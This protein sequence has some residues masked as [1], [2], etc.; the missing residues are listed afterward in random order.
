MRQRVSYAKLEHNRSTQFHAHS[1]KVT[2]SPVGGFVLEPQRGAARSA[3]CEISA[4]RGPQRGRLAGGLGGGPGWGGLGGPGL[5]GGG[6]GGGGLGGGLGGGGE[7]HAT[8]G[9]G[10]VVV[11]KAQARG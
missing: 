1:R 9:S 5:G 11:P 10:E 4:R 3:C 7:T 2:K 8:E 6:L